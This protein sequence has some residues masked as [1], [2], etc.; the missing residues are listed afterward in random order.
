MEV[1]TKNPYVR[2]Q[3]YDDI[4]DPV[5]G[6]I[7]E[8]GTPYLAKYANNFEDGIFNAYGYIMSMQREM[9]RM[10][11]Q[12]ELD[13]RAPGNSGT[14]ADTLDGS[15]NK[16]TLDTTITDVNTAVIAG[17]TEIPV[18]STDGFTAFTQVTIYDDENSEDVLITAVNSSSLTVQALANDYKKGAKVARSTV[19]ID[20]TNK[21]M[22]VGNWSIFSVELVEVV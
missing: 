8:E 15:T 13:G 3:W 22:D 11:V 17:A 10:Q 1:L 9:Q 19:A 12:M 14:F 16:I 5:T 18:D 20:T 2:T 4:F 21:K 7:L 6:E